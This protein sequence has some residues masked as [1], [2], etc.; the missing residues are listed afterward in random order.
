ME[1]KNNSEIAIDKNLN[2][3]LKL[4]L[5]I[6]IIYSIII[7]ITE[8][9]K[10]KTP[11]IIS[12]NPIYFEEKKY[13]SSFLVVS[14]LSLFIH[15]LGLS[16]L[17][18]KKTVIWVFMIYGNLL[19][20]VVLAVILNSGLE[21]EVF[22]IIK[23]SINSLV[24]FFIITFILMLKSNGVSAWSVL[25]E[26]SSKIKKEQAISDNNIDEDKETKPNTLLMYATYALITV[27]L[28]LAVIAL[29]KGL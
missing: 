1:I 9:I 19:L 4:L 23:I 25:W 20:I 10:Y 2:S 28:L 15:V 26:N 22:N 3:I 16:M 11:V 13:F 8:L 7:T 18:I 24:Q 14:I 27:V 17:Q 6:N 29:I 21:Y 12:L 5:N